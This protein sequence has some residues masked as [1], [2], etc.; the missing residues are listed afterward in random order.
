M[1][2]NLLFWFQVIMAWVYTVPLLATLIKGETRGL[3]L[4]MY[5]IFMA[6][7]LLSFFL[8]V[9][10][11]KILR[12]KARKQVIVIFA[13][14]IFLVGLIILAGIG[15]IPWS[16]GDTT[17]VLAIAVLSMGVLIKYK[18]I[19]DA[20]SKAS[21]NVF[22][23]SVPQL[24]LACTIFLAKGGDGLPL[25]S[26]IAGHLTAIPRLMQVIV[27]GKRGWD[28]PT[29]ALLIGEAANVVTW[30]VVTFVWIYFSR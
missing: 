18:G 6:Y 17:I 5:V 29:K 1:M 21:I 26:L 13:Q 19:Q 15:K 23:K 12:E 2:T 25:T 14:W 16:V 28:K 4:A 10:S 9:S 8:A 7:L 24:W 30:F 11:F 3:N 20:Y 27:S 22:C